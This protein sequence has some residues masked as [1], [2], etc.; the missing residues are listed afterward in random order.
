MKRLLRA[1]SAGA[2]LLY[3][4][5]SL[6]GLAQTAGADLAPAPLPSTPLV[7][8]LDGVALG[9]PIGDYIARRGKPGTVGA[10]VYVWRNAREGTRLVTTSSDGTIVV[11]DVKAGKDKRKVDFSGRAVR[12]NVGANVFG[13]TPPTWVSYSGA[14][15][16]RGSLCLSLL[17]PKDDE[18]VMQFANSGSGGSNGIYFGNLIEVFLGTRQAL[19]ANGVVVVGPWAK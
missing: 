4:C 9:S 17:L 18:L 19:L 8:T 11:I 1:L 6:P 15:S 14:N 12:F 10:R 16:C 5:L 3:A 2:I 13:N 7:Y